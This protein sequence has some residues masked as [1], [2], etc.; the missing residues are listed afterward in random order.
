[1]FDHHCIWISNCVGKGNFRPFVLYLKYIFCLTGL[2]LICFYY[3][4]EYINPESGRGIQGFWN[5]YPSPGNFYRNMFQIQDFMKQVDQVLF[6]QFF[7]VWCVSIG[8]QVWTYGH[9]LMNTSPIC[10]LKKIK[11]PW[12]SVIDVKRIVYGDGYFSPMWFI[13]I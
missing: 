13:P 1:M 3:E 5:A 9:L 8:M 12:R 6:I 4:F 11:R 10:R 2:H 7:Q